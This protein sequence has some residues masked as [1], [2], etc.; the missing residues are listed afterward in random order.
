[1]NPR[2]IDR[3]SKIRHCA[4][5]GQE[6]SADTIVYIFHKQFAKI[7]NKELLS[8]LL[9]VLFNQVPEYFWYVPASLDKHHFNQKH[10]EEQGLIYHSK[11]VGDIAESFAYMRGYTDI[12]AVWCAALLHDAHKFPFNGESIDYKNK[13]DHGDTM[14]DILEKNNM[15]ANRPDIIQSIRRHM[16]KFG[17]VYKYPESTLDQIIQYADY[18]ASRNFK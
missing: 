18:T 11:E 12:S 13:K 7:T 1:M 2:Q 3:L 9:E 16:G 8:N 14:A 5:L 10:N 17:G 4:I 15:F 6:I